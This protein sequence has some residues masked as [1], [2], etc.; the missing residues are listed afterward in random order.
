ME[1]C[2]TRRTVHE[3]LPQWGFGKGEEAG[4]VGMAVTEVEHA[5]RVSNSVND[6]RMETAQFS[7]DN[8][9]QHLVFCLSTLVLTEQRFHNRHC[10]GELELVAPWGAAQKRVQQDHETLMHSELFRNQEAPFEN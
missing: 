3:G 5:H 10:I 6:C 7:M 2:A 8:S 4:I 9:V 1:I